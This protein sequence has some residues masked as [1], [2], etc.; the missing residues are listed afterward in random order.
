MIT[1]NGKVLVGLVFVEKCA[2]ISTLYFL[3]T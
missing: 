3:G 2:E 1:E